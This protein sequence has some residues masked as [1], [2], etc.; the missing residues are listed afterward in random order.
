MVAESWW[1][2]RHGPP[3]AVQ[4]H[5][6]QAGERGAPEPMESRPYPHPS[7]GGGDCDCRLLLLQVQQLLHLPQLHPPL[8]RLPPGQDPAPCL[9]LPNPALVCRPLL[10]AVFH[11]HDGP[12]EFQLRVHH[13]LE[14]HLGTA[15]PLRQLILLVCGLAR[16]PPV[17]QAPLGI[18]CLGRPLG[19]GGL[20]PCLG[21]LWILGGW[22]QQHG[23]QLYGQRRRP[24][25]HLLRHR[26]QA[27]VPRRLRPHAACHRRRGPGSQPFFVAVLSMVYPLPHVAVRAAGGGDVELQLVPQLISQQ[28]VPHV[29][30]LHAACR[31]ELAVNPEVLHHAHVHLPA[32]DGQ[33][34]QTEHAVAVVRLLH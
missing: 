6:G 24:P 12:L 22:L 27:A 16:F 18:F 20:L 14:R 34:E 32:S 21:G 1:D 29:G 28:P 8:L 9:D 7:L 31:D 30:V 11:D 19:H 10:P 26:S 17:L 13:K 3:F 23:G 25:L 5:Q 2:A 15:Q 33:L 4:G